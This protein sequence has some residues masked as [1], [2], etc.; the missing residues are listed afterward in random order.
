MVRCC[1]TGEGTWTNSRLLGEWHLAKASGIR[2]DPSAIQARRMSCCLD[3]ERP[4]D[5][6]VPD[7][8]ADA[9]GGLD[10]VFGLGE[11]DSYQN[12]TGRRFYPPA[13]L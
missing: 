10:E 2:S 3:L 1:L 5:G 8:L 6:F 12:V 4:L 11:K 13:R 9:V 7:F